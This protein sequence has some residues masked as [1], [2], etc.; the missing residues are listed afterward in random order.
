MI[1]KIIPVN[2]SLGKYLLY[3][4]LNII[5]LFLM[6]L[7]CVWYPNIRLSIQYSIVNLNEA[8]HLCIFGKGTLRNIL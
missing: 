3:L 6:P 5:T 4:F 8:T 2:Q 7:V 1:N